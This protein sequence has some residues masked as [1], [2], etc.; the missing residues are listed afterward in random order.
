MKI[1]NGGTKIKKEEENIEEKVIVW[2]A[3]ERYIKANE[4]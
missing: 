3:K 2:T 4:V 1:K